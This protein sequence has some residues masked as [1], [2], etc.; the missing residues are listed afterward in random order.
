MFFIVNKTENNISLSDIKINL[1]PRQAIDLD[2][3]MGRSSSEKSSALKQAVKK[4]DVEIRM[5]DNIVN[6]EREIDHLDTRE[7][8]VDLNS[9]KKEIIDEVR[10]VVKEV[11][12]SSDLKQNNSSILKYVF[13]F[14]FSY[15][16]YITYSIPQYK[17]R[18]ILL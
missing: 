11:I 5:K 6:A 7:P 13:F 8:S 12:S 2:R 15:F 16:F 14:T 3:L 10:Q 17:N 18:L 9:M 1:G 4:G